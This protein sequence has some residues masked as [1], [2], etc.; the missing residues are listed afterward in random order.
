MLIYNNNGVTPLSDGIKYKSIRKQKK[1][2]IQRKTLKPVG[3]KPRKEHKVKKTKKSKNLTPKNIKFLKN[4][5]F[6][7]KNE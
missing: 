6:Q 7:V 1:I 2:V 3:K 5:G 4:L